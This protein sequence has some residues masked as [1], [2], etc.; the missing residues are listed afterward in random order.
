MTADCHSAL[1]TPLRHLSQYCSS[2]RDRPSSIDCEEQVK[3][4][5]ITPSRLTLTYNGG[6]CPLEHLASILLHN[7]CSLQS[8]HLLAMLY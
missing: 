2:P 7:H 8:N 1:Q 5:P 3:L 4:Q 6:T